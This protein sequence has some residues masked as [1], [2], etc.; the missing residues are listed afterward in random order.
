MPSSNK[1]DMEV[2]LK[3]WGIQGYCDQGSHLKLNRSSK[4]PSH[5]FWHTLISLKRKLNLLLR[6]TGEKVQV[7]AAKGEEVE[8]N[9]YDRKFDSTLL[10]SGILYI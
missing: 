4:Q 10:G 1:H 2:V 6:C 3:V 8:R 7:F 9:L 5:N